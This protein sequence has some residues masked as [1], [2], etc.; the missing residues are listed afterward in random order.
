MTPR[1][2][3][4]RRGK[5]WK[6]ARMVYLGM[7]IVYVLTGFVIVAQ[8]YAQAFP[9][10]SDTFPVPGSAIRPPAGSDDKAVTEY[11]RYLDLQAFGVEKETYHQDTKAL[12]EMYGIG[13]ITLISIYFFAFAWYARSRHEDLYPVEVYNSYISERGGPIDPFNW[14]VWIVMFGYAVAY[15]AVT[16]VFG[17]LY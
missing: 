12:L 3:G 10:A 11:Y 13:G 14:A 16:L 6:A 7:A 17:Q 8:A 15:I 9:T 1:A 5:V 4:R 2:T